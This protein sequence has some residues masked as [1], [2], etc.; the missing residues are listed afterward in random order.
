[1]EEIGHRF[2]DLRGMRDGQ[3]MAGAF[4]LGVLRVWQPGADEVTD[5]EEPSVGVA[6]SDVQD[7]ARDLF[8]VMDIELPAEQ[9]GQVGSG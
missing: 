9:C 7:R 8:G 1:M 4:D 2:G 5:L 3:R 6:P